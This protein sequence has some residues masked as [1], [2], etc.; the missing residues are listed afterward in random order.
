[1]CEG[2]VRAALQCAGH[3][4]SP[5]VHRALPSTRRDCVQASAAASRVGLR[6]DNGVEANCAVAA[7]SQLE[8]APLPPCITTCR[9]VQS[10]RGYLGAPWAPVCGCEDHRTYFNDT[11]RQ[12]HRV[13]ASTRG[14]C[15]SGAQSCSTN[16]QCGTDG[17]CSIRLNQFSDC[18]AP[19]LGQCWVVPNDCATTSD[20]PHLLP[21]PAPGDPPGAPLPSCLTNCQAIQSGRGYLPAPKNAC[22]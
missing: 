7:I 19:G 11:L 15:G 10:G 3:V 18:G 20:R 2:G 14:E 4:L 9:A 1:M 8:R 13:S 12:Q 5:V 22:Q 17:S 6:A 16:E 21:C